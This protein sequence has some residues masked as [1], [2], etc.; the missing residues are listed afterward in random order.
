MTSGYK[1]RRQVKDSLDQDT[2]D[3]IGNGT[4]MYQGTKWSGSICSK[5]ILHDKT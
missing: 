3:N 2:V 4:G 5:L 1:K